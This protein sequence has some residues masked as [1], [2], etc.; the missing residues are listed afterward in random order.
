MA[1]G[2][3][4]VVQVLLVDADRLL[5]LLDVLGAAF[6]KGGLRLAVALLALL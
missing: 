1:M 3:L 6:A 5:Q 4:K 2:G